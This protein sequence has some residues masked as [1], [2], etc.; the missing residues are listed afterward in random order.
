MRTSAAGIAESS[1][2][3][4]AEVHTWLDRAGLTV[5]HQDTPGTFLFTT[6]ERRS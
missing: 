6:A 5:R 1:L 3:E 4:S 2:F